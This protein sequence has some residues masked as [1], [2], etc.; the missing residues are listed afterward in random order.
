MQNQNIAKLENGRH[1]PMRFIIGVD[2]GG[3]QLRAAL[4]DEEG[5]LYD[6]VRVPTGADEGIDPVV[7]RIVDSV[8]RVRAALPDHGELVGVGVGCPGPLDPFAG[9]V[10]SPPNLPGWDRVPLRDILAARIDLPIELGND[11]NAAVLGEWRFG[12]GRGRRNLVYITVST[13]IGGGVIADGRLVLGYLGS[14]GEVG[15]Q[16][17]DYTTLAY[18]EE[19]ASGT[20]LA[21]AAADAMAEDA[22]SLLHGLASPETV[23]A[24]DVA[25]AAEAGDRLAERLMEREG[26]L[27]GV[28]LVNV[29]HMFAPEQILLG[30]SVVVNN[31][32]L[33]DSARR[34]V[35]ERAY[36]IYH[37]TP[38]ELAALGDRVGVLGAAALFLHMREER[39]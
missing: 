35:R 17:V 13:G 26:E 37:E 15:I 16:I 1:A 32:W 3:T 34:V 7:D 10:L 2:I 29:L 18:W 39:V 20:G 8:A 22:S 12:A 9:M 33:L 38:I 23:T 25:R 5:R 30:G 6:E 31:P 11:A 4:A 36:A 19:L 14:A 24:A 21:R 28:G 27:L